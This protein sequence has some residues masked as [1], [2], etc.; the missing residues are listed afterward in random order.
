MKWTIEEFQREF[1]AR[2]DFISLIP[3]SAMLR[4]DVEFGAWI[5]GE[6]D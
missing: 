1:R 2:I 6:D 5:D 4:W 3:V